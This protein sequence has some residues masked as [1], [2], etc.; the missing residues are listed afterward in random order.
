MFQTTHLPPFLLYD[1]RRN[2]AKLP[3]YIQRPYGNE[4]SQSKQEVRIFGVKYFVNKIIL[5][6]LGIIDRE[7]NTQETII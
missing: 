6:E 2:F 7:F 3:E 4:I 5:Y 1:K